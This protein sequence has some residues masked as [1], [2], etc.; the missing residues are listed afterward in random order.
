M[1]VFRRA[2]EIFGSEGYAFTGTPIHT[3]G[4]SC[5]AIGGMAAIDL[6]IIVTVTCGRVGQI[7]G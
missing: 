6:K 4:G 1:T 3:I 5:P 7:I 2:I